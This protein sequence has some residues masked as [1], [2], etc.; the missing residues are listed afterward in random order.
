MA[1][2]GRVDRTPSPPLHLSLDFVHPTRA[3][4]LG[5]AL[6]VRAGARIYRAPRAGSSMRLESRD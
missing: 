6:G 2:G 4:A 5:E 3:P 1:G